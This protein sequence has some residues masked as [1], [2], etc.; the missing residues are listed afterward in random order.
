[1]ALGRA[2]MDSERLQTGP[3]PCWPCCLGRCASRAHASPRVAGQAGGALAARTGSEPAAV[4]WIV[5]GR[6]GAAAGARAG[7]GDLACGL[8]R[9]RGPARHSACVTPCSV[10]GLPG[11]SIL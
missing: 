4:M 9:S 1:M 10:G 2:G 3:W 5:R 7:V 8:G 6:G 11:R